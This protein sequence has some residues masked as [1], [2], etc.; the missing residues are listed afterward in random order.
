MKRLWNNKLIYTFFLSYLAIIILLSV[1]FFLYSS[2]L[3]RDFYVSSLDKV[4]DQKTRILAKVLPWQE[5]PGSLDAACRALANEL[6]VRITVIA[7]DG[8]VIGDSDEAATDL[9]NHG[10]RPEVIEALS[11]GTGSAVRYSTSVKHDL[12]YRAYF[13]TDGARQRVVR[14]AVSFA[15]VENVTASLARTLL[16]GVLLCSLLGLAVAYFFSRRI[17]NR[18]NRLAEFPKSVAEGRFGQPVLPRIGDDELDVLEQNLRDMSLKIRDNIN[19]LRSEKEKLDSILR[20]MVEGLVVIDPKGRVLLINEQ[21]KAMF[22]VTDEQ[23]RD[24]SFV[25]ISRSPEMRAFLREVLTFDSSKD[26]YSKRISV[27]DRWFRVNAVSLRNGTERPSGS[28]LVF[29]DI[30]EIQRLETVRSD[31]VANVSHELRTPLTAIRGYVETLLHNPP[32][33]AEDARQFLTI[34]ARHS[35]R[36]SRLT[37]D[38]LTLS[39][40]ES[41]AR[42]MTLKPVEAGHL[43]QRVLE[44]FWDRAAKKNVTLSYAVPTEL[45]MILGDSDR[46]QQLFINLV[47]NAVKYNSPGGSVTITGRHVDSGAHAEVEIA[48]IDTGAGISEKDLPRLTERFYRVDKA[49]S[50]EMGGT[51]L[52]LAI[53]KHIVQAHGGELKIESALNKGTTVRVFLP[54]VAAEKHPDGVVVAVH[55]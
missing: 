12:F 20:C 15:E 49:R 31:F 27:E 17:S 10:S 25:E 7:Q 32:T 52:G 54:A 30:T 18:I 4:M 38:L 23:I 41:G 39:D 35:E 50:R 5:S 51:G 6:Q 46:L 40:L 53:V 26:T 42:K 19:E 33:E 1:G 8:T 37:E 44:V 13:Q 22:A 36:L 55:M 28:I 16:A 43:I 9:E 45:P 29:H 3:V 48:V 24:G 21:A 2:N 11:R 47:D 34:I 14:V